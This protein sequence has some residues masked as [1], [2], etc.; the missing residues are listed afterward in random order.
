MVYIS[1]SLLEENVY[2]QSSCYNQEFKYREIRKIS[3]LSDFH[4]KKILKTLVYK[5]ALFLILLK[6][7]K[8]FTNTFFSMRENL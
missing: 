5:E 7:P 3:A 8:N 6:D 1:K 2:V 4:N